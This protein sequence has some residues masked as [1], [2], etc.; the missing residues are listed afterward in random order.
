MVDTM[1]W[2]MEVAQ[3]VA[4]VEEAIKVDGEDHQEEGKIF[5]KCFHKY[6]HLYNVP[7][8]TD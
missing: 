7:V 3:E 1:T 6:C 2:D 5:N 8:L 4:M